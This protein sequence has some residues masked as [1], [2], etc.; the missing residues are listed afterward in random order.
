MSYHFKAQ[1]LFDIF[2]KRYREKYAFLK[3]Y[4]LS[5]PEAD[6]IISKLLCSTTFVYC[7]TY[8]ATIE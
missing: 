7:S 1:C 6:C 8:N 5:S 3:S 4:F 2:C